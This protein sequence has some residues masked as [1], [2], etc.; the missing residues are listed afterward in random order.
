MPPVTFI[1]ASIPIYLAGREHA[2]REPCILVLATVN[3]KSEAFVTDG[4]VGSGTG[5]GGKLRCDDFP[6]AGQLANE[7]RGLST[8]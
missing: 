4:E 2:Y 8:R 5:S 3:D 1:D 7:H 6:A